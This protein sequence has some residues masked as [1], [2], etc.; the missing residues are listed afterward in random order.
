MTHDSADTIRQ[1]VRAR[2][3]EIAHADTVGCGCRPGSCCAPGEI[4]TPDA[5]ALSLGY[6]SDDVT[7]VP[8]GA[9]MGLGCGNPQA[10]AALRP[11]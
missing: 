1:A 8:A 10:L 11:G 2:Y 5:T 3:G 7:A 6:T 4:A 9:N